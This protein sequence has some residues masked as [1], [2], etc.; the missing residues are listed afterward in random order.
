MPLGEPKLPRP[1]SASPHSFPP[2]AS[3]RNVQARMAIDSSLS[4]PPLVD[5]HVPPNS[6]LLLVGIR[7]TR[8]FLRFAFHGTYISFASI[9][10]EGVGVTKNFQA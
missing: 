9:L 8:A 4:Q 3:E 6:W 1:L 10:S 5:I 7:G 2:F